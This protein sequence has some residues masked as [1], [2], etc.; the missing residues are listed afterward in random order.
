MADRSRYA[1]TYQDTALDTADNKHLL[2]LLYDTALRHL[3]QARE[4]MAAGH[5]EAQCEAIIKA[6]RI[7]SALM[8]A[9]D[10]APAPELAANL[11]NLYNWLHSQLAEASI[12][13][14]A[15]VLETVIEV[16]T[17]LG[18]AWREAEIACHQQAA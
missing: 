6:Q 11:W 9:L 12:R 5:L 3:H 18:N 7:L 4:Q 14:E 17:K 13:D 2:V 15:E 16:L 10:S 1:Q 8:S